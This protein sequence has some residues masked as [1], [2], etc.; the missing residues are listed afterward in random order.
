MTLSDLFK[1]SG[2]HC[3]VMSMLVLSAPNNRAADANGVLRKSDIK[4]GLVVVVG[5]DDPTLIA[6][7]R[8]NDGYL[9]QALDTDA[10]KV[11]GTRKHIQSRGLYGKVSVDTFDGEHLPYTDN[12]VNLLVLPKEERRL[13][14]EEIERVLAPG[15]VAVTNR[16]STVTLHTWQ[17]PVPPETDEWTHFLHAADGN[18][19]SCD[20][21]AGKPERLRWVA[22]PRYSRHHD[23]VLGTSAMVT[24]GGR[25][26]SIVDE[27]PR[28]TYHPYIG[29][30]FFLIGRDAFNGLTLWRKRIEDW[31][32][33]SWGL[34]QGVRFAQP[35]QLPKRMVVDGNRLY[36]TLGWNAPVSV[37]DAETG[38]VL[39]VLTEAGYADEL[40]IS[41]S[42]LVI[43]TY[44]RPA[45][46][47]EPRIR[48]PR[49]KGV[50]AVVPGIKKRI[51]V[52]DTRT[53]QT[54]WESDELDGLRGRY[55]AVSPQTHLELTV[56]SGRVFAVTADR[57]VCYALQDGRLLWVQPRPE[58]PTHHMHLGV[59][60]GDN[61]TVLADDDRL[62][63][64][65]PVGKLRNNFHTIPCDLYAFDTQSGEQLWMLERRIGSFAWGIHADVFLI[66]G[67]LW[68]HEHIE[69]EMKG[70]DPVNQES[71]KYALLAIN[72][73]TGKIEKRIDTR[74][75]FNVRHHHRCYR[76]NATERFVFC[77][78]RGTELIDVESGDLFVNHWLRGECRF[79]MVPANGLVYAPP[80]PCSCHARIKVSGMLAL[81]EGAALE[82]DESERLT[83]GPAYGKVQGTSTGAGDWPIHRGTSRRQGFA[84]DTAG[85]LSPVWA[86][87]TGDIVTQATCAGNQVFVACKE[88]HQ[89]RAFSLADGKPDWSFTASGRVDSAPTFSNGYLLFGSSAGKVTCLR[90]RDG[91]LA[92][93]FLAAP[94][95]SQIVA[96]GQ[97][98]SAWP[99]H[100]SVLVDGD[101]AYVVSGR[102][103]YLDG[104]LHAFALDV[105]TGEILKTRRI[106]SEHNDDTMAYSAQTQDA[107]GALNHLLV[108]DGA[109]VYLQSKPLFGE[110]AAATP[111]RPFLM[112]TCGMLDGWMFNRFGWGFV[113]ASGATGTQIVHDDD[114]LYATRATRSFARSTTFVVGS[115]YTLMA[116][117]LPKR[118]EA[119]SQFEKSAFA[120]LGYRAPR[121]KPS[122]SRRIPVRGQA[123]LL[124]ANAL[125]VGG[126][127]DEIS[128]DDPYA[129]FEGRK[130][131]KL[132]TIDRKTGKTLGVLALESPPV[133]DGMS[134]ASGRLLVAQEDGT[135][136]CF[137]GESYSPRPTE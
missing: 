113:G 95:A 62:Y 80:D 7:L 52:I 92:W 70:A 120:N 127:P 49:H 31:G 84:R 110:K 134:Y 39:K 23:E 118:P 101:R 125:L 69:N 14:N 54:L 129:T 63:V 32:W 29:G 111:A 25:I 94:A 22:D 18:A 12:L 61:C 82:T 122:W 1:R 136:C 115:G 112:A 43:S 2:I 6:G 68:S 85:V 57:I 78:R 116:V 66:D 13:P 4:G 38:T 67:Q 108:S 103:S 16:P 40:L 26:F 27:A 133:W 65:Q 72:A 46:P 21:R 121:I 123:M 34:R 58:H 89:V 99:V 81:A 137:R 132:L 45:R 102:S 107:D 90:A 24:G 19:V 75:I 98:E 114:H 86:V 130:G 5:C 93:T 119:Y 124:T 10:A 74:T 55:D 76:N 97:L 59:S 42:K 64:A 53:G 60:M 28:A 9:V 109:T 105:A 88:S 47:T 50:A 106:R 51:V 37:L 30:K 100:G 71:I 56:R 11:A 44:K 126:F 79:G 8:A 87:H 3:L 20:Q 73:A 36:V 96:R 41:G 135:L 131:G 48:A 77:A 128:E 83:R 104:G 33:Q 117:D 35:I 15:G 17:K 91:E